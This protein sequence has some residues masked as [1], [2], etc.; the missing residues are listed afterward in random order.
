MLTA[1]QQHLPLSLYL[2]LIALTIALSFMGEKRLVC[3]SSDL[4]RVMTIQQMLCF[5]WVR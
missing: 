3:C 2:I 5:L 4:C 1:G